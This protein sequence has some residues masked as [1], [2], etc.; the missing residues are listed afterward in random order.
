ML[1]CWVRSL[2]VAAACGGT[3][4]CSGDDD[5]PSPG[6]PDPARVTKCEAFVAAYCPAVTDCAIDGD[7][8]PADER[9]SAIET[10]DEDAK[11]KLNC[12]RAISV[13]STYDACMD[14]LDDP[15]CDDFNEAIEDGDT[16]PL[17]DECNQVIQIL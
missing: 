16:T 5:D 15:D 8:I 13:S 3:L 2:L 1:K 12:S 14:W 10:C 11:N 9:D 4:A 17:P 7:R 6:Q